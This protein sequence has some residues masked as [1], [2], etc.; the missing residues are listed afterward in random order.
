MEKTANLVSMN[1]V[2]DKK[3]GMI[4]TQGT[5]LVPF[6]YE[7]I[8]DEQRGYNQKYKVRTHF[9]NQKRRNKEIPG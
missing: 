3:Y 5:V 9:F 2:I 7:G 6:E 4:D 8:A 1:R